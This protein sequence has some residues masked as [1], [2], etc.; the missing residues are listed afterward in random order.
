MMR[1]RIVLA[2]L[3]LFCANVLALRMAE[4]G[5]QV[6]VNPAFEEGTVGWTVGSVAPGNS[7][8][9][10][11][12]EARSGT[13][14]LKLTAATRDRNMYVHSGWHTVAPDGHFDASVWIKTA[15]LDGTLRI[16]VEFYAADESTHRMTLPLINTSRDRGEWSDIGEWTRYQAQTLLFEDCLRA[17]YRIDITGAT[18]TVW[19]DDTEANYLPLPSPQPGNIEIPP[20]IPHPWMI[21]R[22]GVTYPLGSMAVVISADE[23]RLRRAVA[24]YLSSH[25][26]DPA[27]FRRADDPALRDYPVVLRFG[28][29]TERQFHDRLGRH[30]AGH[31]LSELG[32]EG[33]FLSIDKPVEQVSIL[34]AGNSEQGRFYGLQTLRQLTLGERLHGADIL[35]TP[36]MARRGNVVSAGRFHRPEVWDRM[37]ELKYNMAWSQGS[38]L[39]TKFK[40]RWR[41]PLTA[42]DLA[43]ARDVHE[44]ARSNFVELYFVMGPRS[45]FNPRPPRDVVRPFPGEIQY[46]SDEDIQLIVD[47]FDALVGVGVRHF[48]LNFDDLRNHRE[49]ELIGA[50]KQ[51]WG[52]DDAGRGKAH[53]HLVDEVAKRLGARHPGQVIEI[54]AVPMAYWYPSR[55]GEAYN[56]AFGAGMPEDITTITCS[57]TDA[58]VLA[59]QALTGRPT[60]VWH[61][62]YHEA[63]K[64]PPPFQRTHPIYASPFVGLYTWT[65]PAVRAAMNGF[66]NFPPARDDPGLISWTTPADFAWAPDRYDPGRSFQEGAWRHQQR[67]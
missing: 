2:G 64:Y 16:T 30:F 29:G 4:A 32:T 7:I 45:E 66:L 35:D 63:A 41:E 44:M 57:Y 61:N 14:S 60:L 34:I 15:Q 40:Y 31:S 18:G 52:D 26:L 48:G 21:Q 39:N 58:D 23:D 49:D 9:T 11:G 59:M 47:K 33:Y 13:R 43:S 53:A 12:E 65:D 10:G 28:S 22:S 67:P 5:S 1:G 17:Q 36:T 8:T 24:D 37:G 51:R 3:A 54:I 27:F 6:L 38:Y 50:D 20:L 25:K 55:R 56:R 42:S 46:S 19:V 62:Y